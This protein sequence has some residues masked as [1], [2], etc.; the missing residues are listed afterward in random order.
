MPLLQLPWQ[1]QAPLIAPNP[2]LP[3]GQ[4]LNAQYKNATDATT[5]IA[6]D[7]EHPTAPQGSRYRAFTQV[8]QGCQKYQ[9]SAEAIDF[10]SLRTRT[11]QCEEEV[12]TNLGAM[13]PARVMV[14]SGGG[15]P[16]TL[17]I[18]SSESPDGT[19]FT[20]PLSHPVAIATPTETPRVQNVRRYKLPKGFLHKQTKTLAKT[21]ARRERERERLARKPHAVMRCA[22]RMEAAGACAQRARV[23]SGRERS[24]NDRRRVTLARLL[25][26]CLAL[27]EPRRLHGATCLCMH[28]AWMYVWV[29]AMGG[30]VT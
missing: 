18:M 1:T 3:C 2:P 23:E 24:A 7:S 27:P 9:R 16:L 13:R 30:W 26:C 8:K 4:K 29:D 14:F 6:S 28:V 11:D 21:C 12:R 15:P 22:A 17:P 19:A 20:V 10:Q 25:A 5:R